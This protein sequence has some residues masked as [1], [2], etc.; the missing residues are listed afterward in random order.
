MEKDIEGEVAIGVVRENGKFLLMRRSE[1]NSSSGKWNFPGGRIEEEETVSGAVVRE[2]R[3]ETGLDT[4]LV[5][6]G[7]SFLNEGEL[8]WWKVYPVLLE[9]SKGVETSIEMN[10]EHDK[11]EW[12][13]IEE[14]DDFDTLGEMK[15]PEKLDLA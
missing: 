3:E 7:D 1:S 12:I 10:H 14:L 8:G 9:T 2:I 15:A 6:I 5:R 13:E 4:E 11:Y